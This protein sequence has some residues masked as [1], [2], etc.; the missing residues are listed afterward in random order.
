MW[1]NGRQSAATR[2]HYNTSSTPNSWLEYSV[3]G[4]GFHLRV[5]ELRPK[6]PPS[7]ITKD[8]NN[9]VNQ[10]ELEASTCSWRKARE[11]VCERVKIDFGITSDWLTK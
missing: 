6:Q 4:N 5:V 1:R 10:S 7:P 8:L 9:P 11:N 2:R 3:R